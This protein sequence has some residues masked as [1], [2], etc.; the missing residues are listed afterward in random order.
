MIPT[1]ERS[2]EV[3][4]ATPAK[5]SRRCCPRMS[6]APAAAG[7]VIARGCTPHPCRPSSTAAIVGAW[8]TP[9][10][11]SSVAL[12]ALRNRA[13][14]RASPTPSLERSARVWELAH[15]VGAPTSYPLTAGA[16]TDQV[17]R[18][19]DIHAA[20]GDRLARA[21]AKPRGA[22]RGGSTADLAG[23]APS[24][25]RGA[26]H[27]HEVSPT[28][29]CRE[30][31]RLGGTRFTAGARA[32]LSDRFLARRRNDLPVKRSALA[33]Q[34]GDG[35]R[36]DVLQHP[37]GD[38]VIQRAVGGLAEH[39][40]DASDPLDACAARVGQRVGERQKSILRGHQRGRRAARRGAERKDGQRR[41]RWCDR[42]FPGVGDDVAD[43][44]RETP[45]HSRA[46][47]LLRAQFELCAGCG[48]APFGKSAV[49]R[50]ASPPDRE[51][52]PGARGGHRPR[53]ARDCIQLRPPCLGR[54]GGPARFILDVIARY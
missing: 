24:H 9:S 48:W 15:V 40:R 7:G 4:P 25:A 18:G 31:R 12:T 13:T 30:P 45:S 11:R 35:L 5:R 14:S 42:C 19:T 51:L 50:N 37:C 36:G 17:K 29:G 2:H 38:A 8:L 3:A 21:G 46:G 23:G 53:S 6:C 1:A 16:E 33:A 27:V 20:A 22:A 41:E 28:V 44:S 43:A 26:G 32:L 34:R 39:P 47:E 52:H 54:R 10:T 49:E